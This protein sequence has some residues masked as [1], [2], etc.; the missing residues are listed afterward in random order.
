M[1]NWEKAYSTHDQYRADLVKS[2]L[3]NNKVPAIIINKKDTAYNAFGEL[4][5][6]VNKHDLVAAIKVIENEIDFE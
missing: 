3:E 6:Y 4:E 5:V 1:K 2:L